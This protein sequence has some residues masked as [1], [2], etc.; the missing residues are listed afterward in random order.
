VYCL[1]LDL[2]EGATRI[3]II[4]SPWRRHILRAR[5]PDLITANERERETKHRSIIS[6]RISKD[7]MTT[8]KA[9]TRGDDP[10]RTE[11]GTRAIKVIEMTEEV[12]TY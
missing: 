11:D 7:E 1:A 8:W 5:H 3:L 2:P 9:H 4:A 6:D 12:S 10:G